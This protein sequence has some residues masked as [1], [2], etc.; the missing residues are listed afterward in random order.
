M[1]GYKEP[2]CW[3]GAEEREGLLEKIDWFFILMR[4]DVHTCFVFLSFCL[5]VFLHFQ[6]SSVSSIPSVPVAPA[7][8]RPS[9]YSI[10]ALP[11][12]RQRKDIWAQFPVNLVPLGRG[13]DCAERH[14]I[15]WNRKKLLESRAVLPEDLWMTFESTIESHLLQALRASPSWSV[16]PAQTNKQ[17]CVIR[18]SFP[19]DIPSKSTDVTTE[20]SITPLLTCLNDIKRFFPVVWHCVDENNNEGKKRYTIELH[21]T[22]IKELSAALGYNAEKN[23]QTLLLT[24]L[25]ASTSWTVHPSETADEVCRLTMA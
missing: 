8:I 10:P 13:D 25:H 17:L 3:K 4:T 21:H 20:R 7:F 9:V 15:V 22:A 19:R 23:I 1:P 24:A 12:L 16:E 14:A 6:M 18:M 11:L 5:S 2:S